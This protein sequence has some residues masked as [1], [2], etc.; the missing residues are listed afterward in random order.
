MSSPPRKVSSSAEWLGDEG[1]GEGLAVGVGS[2]VEV[3]S[4]VG[5]GAG[6]EVGAPI[7]DTLVRTSVVVVVVASEKIGG[8]TGTKV[9][10]I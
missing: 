2:G 3:C 8:G 10:G 7:S 9:G 1:E 4:V 6:A 5:V